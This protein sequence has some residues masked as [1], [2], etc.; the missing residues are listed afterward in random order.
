MAGA[1]ARS[2]RVGVRCCL[3]ADVD[4]AAT[5][6]HLSPRQHSVVSIIT[7]EAAIEATVGAAIAKFVA[8]KA[9]AIPIDGPVGRHIAILIMML[10]ITDF[11]IAGVAIG[12]TIVTIVAI[13]GNGSMTI[14][15][16]ILL[17][18]FH[19]N[20]KNLRQTLFEN[21]FNDITQLC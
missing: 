11:D 7:I 4:R 21:I 17:A 18:A 20:L 9:V 6:T 1:P 12:I 14:A 5:R 15:V 10:R 16:T 8:V 13:I 3:D 2:T 19:F